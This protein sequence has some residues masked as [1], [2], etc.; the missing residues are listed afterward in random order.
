LIIR[1]LTSNPLR[2]PNS[3]TAKR[4]EMLIRKREGQLLNSTAKFSGAAFRN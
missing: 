2:I 1:I 4:E 3:K